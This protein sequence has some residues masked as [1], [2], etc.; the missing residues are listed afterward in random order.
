MDPI[1]HG[2]IG[3]NL[4][5]SLR[6]SDRYKV[7]RFTC[8]LSAIFP[9]IDITFS[10]VGR[11]SNNQL[12][13]INLHRH[14]T[15]SLL[16]MPLFCLLLSLLIRKFINEA[17]KCSFSTIY[18]A[19][20]LGYL[21]HIVV[22][23]LNSYGTYSL[24]PLID[25]KLHL[26]ILPIIDP[27]LLMFLLCGILIATTLD[28]YKLFVARTACFL[29][30][31]YIGFAAIQRKEVISFMRQI[32]QTR[33]HYVLRREIVH[34]SFGNTMLWNST[35]ECGEY[36]YT[37]SVWVMLGDQPKLYAGTR[38]YN[39]NVSTNVD[40]KKFYDATYGFVGCPTKNNNMLIDLRYFIVPNKITPMISLLIDHKQTRLINTIGDTSSYDIEKFLRMVVGKNL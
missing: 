19:S 15:H 24:W 32:Q 13:Y 31:L 18:Q 17:K 12:P 34:P 39:C 4:G 26:D 21:S 11:L 38:T 7:V 22:D 25:R 20:I 16:L 5:N 14:F 27:V 33:G 9:D 10:L 2:L 30:V 37:D 29:V 23:T 3:A 6:S 35:Y 8:I 28:K 40:I 36:F 1:T